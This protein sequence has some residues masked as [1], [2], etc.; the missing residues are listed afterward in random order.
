M[1][2]ME[3]SELSKA[4][5]RIYAVNE[6]NCMCRKAPVTTSPV[7]MIPVSRNE[8]LI[9]GLLVPTSGEIQL[10]EKTP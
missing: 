5:H 4:F 10:L 6:R 8:K 1:N 2:A 7:K 9:C 3:T